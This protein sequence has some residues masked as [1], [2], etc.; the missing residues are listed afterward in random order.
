VAARRL[1][2]IGLHPKVLACDATGPLPGRYDRF[3]SMVSVKP[4]PAS[5]L[6]ALKPGRTP[7]D[8]P[9]QHPASS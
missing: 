9:G 2:A 1:D 8:R 3:V 4:I 7:G 5:R 6:S